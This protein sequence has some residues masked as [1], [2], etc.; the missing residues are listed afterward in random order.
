M[1]KDNYSA[2]VK[3]VAGYLKLARDNRNPAAFLLGAGASISANIPS[4]PKLVEQVVSEFSHCIDNLPLADRK[5]YGKCMSALSPDERRT[6]I[7]PHLDKAKINWGHIALAQI[8]KNG[9]ISRVLTFNFD[10]VLESAL[11]LIGQQCPVYDF[12]AYPKADLALLAEPSIIHLHGQSYGFVHLNTEEETK[13]HKEAISPIISN[14]INTRP[15][16][17]IGYSGDCDPSAKTLQ[18]Q[19]SDQ[20]R[21][22]WLEYSETAN[23]PQKALTKTNSYAEFT[24]GLDFDLFMIALATELQVWPPKILTNSSA[25]LLDELSVVTDYPTSAGEEQDVFSRAKKHLRSQKDDLIVKATFKGTK[26]PANASVQDR[27]MYTNVKAS[28]LIREGSDLLWQ[29]R[30]LTGKDAIKSYEVALEKL[31]EAVELKPK[32]YK[33]INYLGLTLMYLGRM[34]P[35]KSG[36]A[37]LEQAIKYFEIVISINPNFSATVNNLGLVLNHLADHKSG[38]KAQNLIEQSI[39]KYEIAIEMGP[40]SSITLCN[41]GS[42]TRDLAGYK[43]AEDAHPLYL[44]AIERL[45]AAIQIDPDFP[46]SYAHW[47]LTLGKMA[48][49]TSGEEASTLF[50]QAIDK[51]EIA[52]KKDPKLHMIYYTQGRIFALKKDNEKM[53]KALEKAKTLEYPNLKWKISKQND[54]KHVFKTDK[55]KAFLKTLND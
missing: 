52:I 13:R 35:D 1:Q 44:L 24:G 48:E 30:L 55:M 16:I 6:L 33:A 51:C 2:I 10:L 3:R 26:L 5:N 29:A 15:T 42:A 28:T 22:A 27:K 36:Q 43:L 39:E 25:H 9:F 37:L 40:N 50:N 54:F 46:Y 32:D 23:E 45:Q 17:I 53:F 12:G 7:K 18:E 38:K 31:H 11:S 14:T 47:A 20:H 19:Y 4:A 41:L 8:I 34:K 21:L 49:R